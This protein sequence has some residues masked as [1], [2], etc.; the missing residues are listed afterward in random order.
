[1]CVVAISRQRDR[2]ICTILNSI[3]I[4]AVALHLITAD[5]EISR[6]ISWTITFGF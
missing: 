2:S 5:Y 4:S 3:A 6:G 1:M